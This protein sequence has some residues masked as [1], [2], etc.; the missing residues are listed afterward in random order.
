MAMGNRLREVA[1]VHVG[2]LDYLL[3]FCVATNF[4]IISTAKAMAWG[5]WWM[6]VG[7]AGK[8]G[9]YLALRVQMMEVREGCSGC[10]CFSFMVGGWLLFIIELLW[11]LPLHAPCW[12]GSQSL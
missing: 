1:D 9:A 8:C 5:K 11:Y 4:G 7:G 3:Q 10:C 6:N 2:A 12:Y